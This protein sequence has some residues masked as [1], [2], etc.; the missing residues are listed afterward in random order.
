MTHQSPR[1]RSTRFR[2]LLRACI[3]LF[4]APVVASTAGC[5]VFAGFAKVDRAVEK[6]EALPQV[7]AVSTKVEG[8][9]LS[10]R[11][12]TVSVASLS[13]AEA[14]VAEMNDTLL[15][16]VPEAALIVGETTVSW[17]TEG[18][19]PSKEIWTLLAERPPGI[20]A[21]AVDLKKA[22]PL[23]W[24]TLAAG[25]PISLAN[26]IVGELKFPS[27]ANVS[28]MVQGSA[29]WTLEQVQ[30]FSELVNQGYD[31]TL[32]AEG[33]AL[34]SPEEALRVAALPLPDVG[35]LFAKEG[36]TTV[37]ITGVQQQASLQLAEALIAAHAAT[38]L[39]LRDSAL[40]VVLRPDAN[41][42]AE[43]VEA[44]SGFSGEL[45]V[46][47]RAQD[48]VEVSVKGNPW[49]V[50]SNAWLAS[51]LVLSEMGASRIGVSGGKVMLNEPLTTE[52][53]TQLR[54]VGFSKVM[55]IDASNGTFDSTATGKAS[56][57]A[58]G[59]EAQVIWDKAAPEG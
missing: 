2:R 52:L 4:V 39:D 33:L 3:A 51:S 12:V 11:S 1:P 22:E 58:P 23:W 41:D 8:G 59:G 44:A 49:S 45:L 25:T 24:V 38:L 46:R 9:G 15:G 34:A 17:L 10:M 26:R 28:L 14:L 18:P 47:S 29:P 30:H 35:R 53:A 7:L 57:G 5:S 50:E 6:L 32:E 13:D 20:E 31:P 21:E 43:A 36:D 37:S 16:V 27:D 48:G 55:T 42:V 19:I 56:N 40:T 54:A